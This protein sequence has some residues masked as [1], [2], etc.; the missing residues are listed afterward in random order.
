M[1]KTRGGGLL[2]I[3]EGGHARVTYVELFFDLV[4]VFAITQLSHGLIG[5]P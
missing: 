5:H 3:R 4:F 2:R 1:S